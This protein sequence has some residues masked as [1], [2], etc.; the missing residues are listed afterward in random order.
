MTRARFNR[1]RNRS[2]L[3]SWWLVWRMPTLLLIVMAVWWF[4]IRPVTQEQGWIE[5]DTGFAFCAI[6]GERQPGC[7]VD[8]DTVVIGFGQDLSLIHI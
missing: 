4:G 6:Q 2:A 1:I 8:G 3:Q 5:V 7:V